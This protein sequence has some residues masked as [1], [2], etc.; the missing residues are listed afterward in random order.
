[1]Q[2]VL[3]IKDVIVVTESIV[4]DAPQNVHVDTTSNTAIIKWDR[5]ANAD[6]VLVRGYT[7][8]YA[9]HRVI[10]EGV[11]SNRYIVD[12]LRKM[13]DTQEIMDG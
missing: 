9:Q 6:R 8:S 1:V 2:F 12:Q 11:D 4:P 3:I 7:L 10:I 13:R 5:P